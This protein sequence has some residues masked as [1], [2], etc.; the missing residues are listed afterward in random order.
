MRFVESALNHQEDN[1]ALYN[2]GLGEAVSIKNLVGKIIEASGRDLSV[3]HDLSKPT[4]KT[5]LF[6]DCSK[7]TRELGWSPQISLDEGIKR[8]IVWYRENIL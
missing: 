1:Y 3:E 5:S 4:I 8:T 6:L 7:A 2:V